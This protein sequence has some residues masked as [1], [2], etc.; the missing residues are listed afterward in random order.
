MGSTRL[1]GKVLKEL[2]GEPMLTRLINRSQRSKLVDEIIV[3]T[4][5]NPLD[6]PIV[7]LCESKGYKYYRGSEADVLDRYYRAALK[8]KGDVIVRLC[9]DDP[10]VDSEIIDMVV[11]EF[12]S[13]YPEVDYVSNAFPSCGF[14]VGLYAEVISFSA[15]AR[16][17]REDNNPA[18]REHATPYI[19]RHPEKFKV[20]PVTHTEDLSYMRWT[21]DTPDDL[22]FVRKIYSHFGDDRFSWRDVLE[23]L[24]RHPEWLDINRHVVQKEAP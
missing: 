2:L 18:W 10:L 6:N 8:H 7:E 15:L 16:A 4:T 14:P 24:Q 13:R 21:V 22:E 11:D 17:W 1:P 19:Y 3:A 23:V 20:K 12:L 9:S 5:I